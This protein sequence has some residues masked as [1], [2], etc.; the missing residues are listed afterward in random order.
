M[1][2]DGSGLVRR[3]AELL[4]AGRLFQDIESLAALRTDV[5]V[6]DGQAHEELVQ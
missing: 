2:L 6:G 1:I 3:A 5:A 4:P